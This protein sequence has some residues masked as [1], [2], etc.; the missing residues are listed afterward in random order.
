MTENLRT[1]VRAH[2]ISIIDAEGEVIAKCIN[3]P[4]AVAIAAFINAT[5][6]AS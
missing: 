3:T 5:A 2:G 4:I 6:Q 1:P